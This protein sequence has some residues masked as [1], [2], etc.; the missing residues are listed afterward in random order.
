[1]NYFK[2]LYQEKVPTGET[3]LMFQQT[4]LSLPQIPT[5]AIEGLT[6]LLNTEEIYTTL[7]Q[8]GLDRAPGPIS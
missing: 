2:T 3:K 5:T 1:V 8:I 6:K 4:H 7:C